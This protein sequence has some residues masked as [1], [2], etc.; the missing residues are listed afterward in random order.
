[1]IHLTILGIGILIVIFMSISWYI[2]AKNYEDKFPR[3][4][5]YNWTFIFLM[6]IVL[7]GFGYFTS[8]VIPYIGAALNYLKL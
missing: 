2:A 8:M 5:S 3:W 7:V 6:Y 4:M 1:M